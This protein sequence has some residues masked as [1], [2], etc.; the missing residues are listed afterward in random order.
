MRMHHGGDIYRNAVGMDFS[1][2]VNPYPLPENVALAMQ[3]ALER[4]GQYPDL[5]QERLRNAVA[6]RYG[7]T[8][9]QIV[10]GNGASELLMAVFHAVRPKRTIVREWDY[11]GY[12]RC[13]EAVGSDIVSGEEWQKRQAEEDRDALF[14]FSLPNNPTGRL[15]EAEELE[16]YV[17]YCQDSNCWLV[18]DASFLD[19]T[20]QAEAYW[21]CLMAYVSRYD[22]CMILSSFTKSFALPGIRIGFLFGAATA[23]DRVRRQLREWNVSAVAEEAGLACLAERGYLTE[24][25][26][27]IAAERRRVSEILEGFGLAV[28]QSDANFVLFRSEIPLYEALLQKGMLIR[29]CADFF[30]EQNPGDCCDGRD[31]GQAYFYRIAVRRQEEN[32][33][34][35]EHIGRLIKKQGTNHCV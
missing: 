2:S 13:A 12:R 15:P 28:G 32:D 3:K 30:A 19:L 10:C 31:S 26:G 35:L 4:A 11:G 8:P 27:K 7:I 34:L 22:R 16:E 6:K 25:V 5:R 21:K 1:T 33:L 9:D 17:R 18:I 14:V 29:D 23:A 20:E 24:C